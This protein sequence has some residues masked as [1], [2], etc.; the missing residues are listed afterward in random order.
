[1]KKLRLYS[2]Y[3]HLIKCINYINKVIG[4]SF[5]LGTVLLIRNY[6]FVYIYLET[7]RNKIRPKRIIV[8]HRF[9]F[10]DVSIIN[11]IMNY[12]GITTIKICKCTTNVWIINSTVH[13]QCL[14]HNMCHIRLI[15]HQQFLGSVWFPCQFSSF[16]FLSRK[17]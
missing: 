15:I 5:E 14:L 2:S 8:R 13:Y 7:D 3:I 17:E 16:I 1:M 12:W 11:S 10:L 4:Y 6:K 9:I